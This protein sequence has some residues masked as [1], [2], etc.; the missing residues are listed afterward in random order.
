MVSPARTTAAGYS[1][2]PMHHVLNQHCGKSVATHSMA[3]AHAATITHLSAT[4]KQTTL[5]SATSFDENRAHLPH[6]PEGCECVVIVPLLKNLFLKLQI[7]GT[8]GAVHW[9]R[10]N[11][12][13]VTPLLSESS[14]ELCRPRHLGLRSPNG[15][16]PGRGRRR[17]PAGRLNLPTRSSDP[18]PLPGVPTTPS[19]ANLGVITQTAPLK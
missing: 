2:V 19:L 3:D 9:F 11:Q 1:K 10:Q 18:Q 13:T 17:C 16:A 15:P 14:R 4:V 8:A 5:F 6:V 12:H 7:I